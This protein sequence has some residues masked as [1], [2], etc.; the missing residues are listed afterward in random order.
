MNEN[1][2]DMGVKYAQRSRLESPAVSVII[3]VYNGEAYLE[4]CLRSV[5][6]QSR[7]DIEIVLIDDASVDGTVEL[8]ESLMESSSMDYLLL[9]KT[10][11]RG[12]SH[13]R[14]VGI[15]AARGQ[16]LFF[17]DSDD[18]LSENSLEI[19][20]ENYRSECV[21]VLPV[22]RFKTYEEL[23]NV[24]YSVSQEQRAYPTYKMIREFNHGYVWGFLIERELVQSKRILFDENLS[25]REDNVWLAW[26]MSFFPAV[27]RVSGAYY[28]YRVTLHS[29]SRSEPVEHTVKACCSVNTLLSWQF[30]ND[31]AICI[32]IRRTL[33]NAA[34][35]EAA[36][37]GKMEKLTPLRKSKLSLSIQKVYASSLPRIQKM[38]ECL[39][40]ALPLLEFPLYR[41][42][43]A[44]SGKSK[45]KNK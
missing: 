28:A 6:A 11:N 8:A 22:I 45:P 7:H 27:R 36:Y 43:F 17:L 24:S 26:Y 5:F 4:D 31:M 19:L 41:L 42:V 18:V 34:F 13:S 16:Y 39:F 1:R 35:G 21:P 44:I 29:L 2:P 23:D 30:A 40:C 12:V 20:L 3:P 37:A 10:V 32:S 25:Y 38:L 9:T 14:N 15:Q 33:Y